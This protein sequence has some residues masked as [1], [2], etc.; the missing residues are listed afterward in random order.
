MDNYTLI[1]EI[2]YDLS[3]ETQEKLT[4]S[5]NNLRYAC[6]MEEQDL[7]LGQALSVIFQTVKFIDGK[8]VTA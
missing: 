2:F 6:A 3:P 7:T 4:N 1:W 5:A 8:E